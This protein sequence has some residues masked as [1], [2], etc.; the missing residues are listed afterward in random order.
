MAV[1][2]RTNFSN[3]AVG[4]ET[5]VFGLVTASVISALLVLAIE[6]GFGFGFGVTWL[7]SKV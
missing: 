5:V 1:G 7:C 2:S 3:M 6:S 4:Q